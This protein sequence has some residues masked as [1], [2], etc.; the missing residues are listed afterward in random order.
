MQERR[1]DAREEGIE[2]REWRRGRK[3]SYCDSLLTKAVRAGASFASKASSMST[4][5][6][7]AYRV[8][9]CYDWII[10][11]NNT[12]FLLFFFSYLYLFFL[13]GCL[14][15]IGLQS[16]HQWQYHCRVASQ[17]TQ[18]QTPRVHCSHAP[19]KSFEGPNFRSWLVW[20]PVW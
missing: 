11:K 5:T 9:T 2:E 8:N 12:T 3:R 20:S 4:F 15:G 10:K 7:S 6:P 1:G 17:G 14:P 16:I 18:P 13:F 19:C